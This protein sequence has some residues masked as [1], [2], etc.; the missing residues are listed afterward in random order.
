MGIGQPRQAGR[1][2]P[3]T[4][5][6]TG[7]RQPE[8]TTRSSGPT[9]GHPTPARIGTPARSGLLPLR[10]IAKR[11]VIPQIRRG[12]EPL[13]GPGE[14]Q[15]VHLRNQQEQHTGHAP[16]SLPPRWPPRRSAR[17]HN[18]W[19]QATRQRVLG[20]GDDLDGGQGQGSARISATVRSVGAARCGI[21]K[22]A[23]ASVTKVT[24]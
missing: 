18:R 3:P 11:V 6:S 15:Q 23:V 13:S 16:V 5:P 21:G 12:P 20:P 1:V 24:S 14:V 22:V 19:C 7:E 17:R 9:S 4:A 8:T 10:D 2:Q